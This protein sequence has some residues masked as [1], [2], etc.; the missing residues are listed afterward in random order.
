MAI[1][2]RP[3]TRADA[4]A[5]SRLAAATFRD[6]FAGSSTPADMAHYLAEAFTPAQQAREIADPAAIVLLAEDRSDAGSVSLIGYAHLVAG[7]APAAVTGPAAIE[8][9]RLYVDRAW[10][11]RGVAHLLMDAGLHAARRRGAETVWLGVWEHNPR[12]I[13][14]YSKYGFTRVGQHTFVLGTDAQ[15]DW[16]FARPL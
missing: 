11:G 1:D 7:A 5:L 16:L 8:L 3:A 2:V 10:H 4:D 13:A 12:A 6:T 15:T 14:F 9:K